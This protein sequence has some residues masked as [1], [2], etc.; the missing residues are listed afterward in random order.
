[1]RKDIFLAGIRLLGLWQL[2]GSLVSFSY[3]IS[4]YIGLTRPQ[5]YTHEYNLLRFG[6]EFIV[7]SF[8]VFRPHNIFHFI[9]LLSLSYDEDQRNNGNVN[10][11]ESEVK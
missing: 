6:V 3:I 8:L 1:M 7:G 10:E 4:D 9:Q 11:A 5:S 2:C